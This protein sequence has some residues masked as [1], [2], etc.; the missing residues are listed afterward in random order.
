MT[1][2]NRVSDPHSLTIAAVLRGPVMGPLV[3]AVLRW[4]VLPG[5]PA[6]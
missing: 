1:E 5:L 2:I 6:L 4:A 3:Q